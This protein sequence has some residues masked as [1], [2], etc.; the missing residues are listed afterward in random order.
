M[1]FQPILGTM[2][3]KE[4]LLP[5]LFEAL[6][7]MKA[8]H[9]F[10]S[11]VLDVPHVCPNVTSSPLQGAGPGGS[12]FSQA[13]T[14]SHA[15]LIL[16]WPLAPTSV[17]PQPRE[18]LPG[19]QPGLLPD[20]VTHPICFFHEEA[21]ARGRAQHG[22][23]QGAV[24]VLTPCHGPGVPGPKP[25]VLV[26]VLRLTGPLQLTDCSCARGFPPFLKPY[27]LLVSGALQDFQLIPRE[28][29]S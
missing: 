5:F 21:P 18:W 23:A 11:T 24:L 9:L 16:T 3:M 19:L 20:G 13:Y 8:S 14:C 2:G 22:A 12:P 6:G 4:G 1:G 25:R 27:S 26:S 15:F 7:K 29:P 28:C 10:T 17:T